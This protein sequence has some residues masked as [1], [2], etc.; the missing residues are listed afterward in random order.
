VL[1]V[2]KLAGASSALAAPTTDYFGVELFP[3]FYVKVAVLGYRLLRN[4]PLPDGNKRCAFLA[5]IEMVERTGKPWIVVDE[6][7]TVKTIE[8]AAAGILDETS[9]ADWVR[10]QIVD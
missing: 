5:M 7:D 10:R 6:D 1:R 3:D 8:S 4:H 9:F 2:L